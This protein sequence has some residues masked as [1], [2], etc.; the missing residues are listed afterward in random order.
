MKNVK[1]KNG[2]SRKKVNNNE[3]MVYSKNSALGHA[4]E[5]LFAYWISRYFE[6][7]CRLLDIDMGIDAQVEVYTND[8]RSTGSFIGVQIKTTGEVVNTSGSVP[9]SLNNLVYWSTCNDPIVVVLISLDSSNCQMEPRIY[10]RHLDKNL[11]D[12]LVEK[13]RNNTEKETTLIFTATDS[14]LLTSHKITWSKLWMRPEDE[15]YVKR[16]DGL[17]KALQNLVDDYNRGYERDKERIPASGSDFCVDLNNFLN[18]CD[19]LSVIRGSNKQLDLQFPSVISFHD[20]Y[21]E[22]EDILLGAFTLMVEAQG[23]YIKEDLNKYVAPINPK[24]QAIFTY[25]YIK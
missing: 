25:K 23:Y 4:G 5:Y 18:D 3:W 16:I 2:V 8:H 13:A 24:L 14:V 12:S 19:E 15:S 1:T 20:D 21:Y 7:P 22:Y 6:W 9:L 11:I 10:W 17:H